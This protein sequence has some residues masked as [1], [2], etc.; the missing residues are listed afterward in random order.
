[1][2]KVSLDVIKKLQTEPYPQ[3]T[4][5]T[6]STISDALEL[7]YNEYVRLFK[8]NQILNDE[9]ASILLERN[10]LADQFNQIKVWSFLI[11]IENEI[12]R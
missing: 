1:M 10:N 12:I 3:L 9:L 5:A 2:S 4:L 7:Y 11:M 8:Q 6:H